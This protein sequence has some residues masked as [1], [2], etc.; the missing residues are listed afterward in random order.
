[1]KKNKLLF[2]LLA[3]L[4]LPATAE[5]EIK[6]VSGVYVGGHI[7]RARPTTITNLRQSGFTYALLFNVNVEAD[8]TLTTDGET[9]CKDGQYVFHF[10]ALKARLGARASKN[11]AG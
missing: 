2:I 5:T 9:I 4:H 6:A 8:G 11:K 1:M 3:L 7:R 10:R